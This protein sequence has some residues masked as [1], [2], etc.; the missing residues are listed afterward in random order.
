MVEQAGLAGVLGQSGVIV[1]LQR[2]LDE[3]GDVLDVFSVAVFGVNEAIKVPELE[4]EGARDFVLR[5]HRGD[6]VDDAAGVVEVALVVV[7][8]IEDEEIVEDGG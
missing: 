2:G 1:R 5:H 6:P 4:L 8:E 3:T 7:G